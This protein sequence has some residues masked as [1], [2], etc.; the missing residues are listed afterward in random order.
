MLAE[1]IPVKGDRTVEREF[2]L[3]LASRTISV[4]H[5]N[6]SGAVCILVTSLPTLRPSLSLRITLLL[7]PTNLLIRGWV[8]EAKDC[9]VR[10]AAA[11]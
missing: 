5:F 6:P 3:D 11:I 1:A 10:T 8:G 7:I 2:L 4:I 9:S